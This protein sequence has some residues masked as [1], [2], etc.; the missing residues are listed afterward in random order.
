MSWSGNLTEQGRAL[1]QRWTSEGILKITEAKGYNG[2][3]L[4]TT[5]VP[6]DCIIISGAYKGAKIQLIFP[7]MQQASQIDKIDIVA[8]L[9][10]S[11][12]TTIIGDTNLVEYTSPVP[13]PIASISDNPNAIFE[14]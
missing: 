7:P 5:I 2:Q 1:L 4:V 6:G 3:T 14:L 10:S 13:Q 9:E 12:G 11:S 8:H